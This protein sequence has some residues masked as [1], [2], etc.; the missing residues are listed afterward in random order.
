MKDLHPILVILDVAQVMDDEL[1]RLLPEAH[2]DRTI[3]RLSEEI[4]RRPAPPG[5]MK[6]PYD[7]ETLGRGVESL[8]G[9]ARQKS[10]DAGGANAV[11]HIAGRAPLPLF[12]QLGYALNK[13]TGEIWVLNPYR[14]GSWVK[15]PAWAEPQTD[16]A[17]FFDGVTGLDTMN[18]A[19]GVVSVYVSTIGSPAPDDAFF[20]ALER[21]GHPQAGIVEIRTGAAGDVTPENVAKIAG[22]L[23]RE[24][25]RIKDT[26]PRSEGMALF[27]AGPVPLAF[28]VGRSLNFHAHRALWVMNYDRGGPGV[29]PGY[30]VAITLP[31]RAKASIVSDTAEDK[32]ARREALDAMIEGIEEL[33]DTLKKEDFPPGDAVVPP[34]RYLQFLKDLRFHRE[35]RGDVFVLSVA[36]REMS[37]G[38]GLLE[39]VRGVERRTLRRFAQLLVLHE[40]YHDGQE[41]RTSNHAEIGRAGVVL[42]EIDFWADAFSLSTSIA[43]DLRQGGPRAQARPS[44]IA[45]GWVDTAITGI[46]AFDRFDQGARMDRLYER[47]LR[48]YLIWHLQHQRAAT[49]RGRDDVR[50]LF[51]DRLLVELAPLDGSLDPRGDKLVTQALPGRTEIFAVL[52]GHLVRRGP[53][54]DFEPSRVVDAVRGFD[55]DTIRKIMDVLVEEHRSV[56]V[57][58]TAA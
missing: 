9:K 5:E 49:V 10:Q 12:V 46:E 57:P 8:A 28:L 47:R 52:R 19:S 34:Q 27:V 17:P 35:P 11:L 42:E 26:Y 36:H 53:R 4:F 3:L 30:E 31:F 14:G 22:E 43:W 23:A 33:R 20:E 24:L 50:D 6:G 38:R 39:A 2:R 44:E 7:W 54:P 32:L 21:T 13:F 51:R 29:E 15:Y 41:L 1:L 58:W 16:T 55:R 25:P 48:R 18:K 45:A 37:V 56:L 40:L